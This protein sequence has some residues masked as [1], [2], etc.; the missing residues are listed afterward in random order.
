MIPMPQSLGTKKPY[1][2]LTHEASQAD[3]T[4]DTNAPD[5]IS[6]LFQ[7]DGIL[8]RH[9]PLIFTRPNSFHSPPKKLIENLENLE[10]LLEK[11][12]TNNMGDPAPKPKPKTK[13][14]LTSKTNKPSFSQIIHIFTSPKVINALEKNKFLEEIT[15]D[16]PAP[17][18]TNQTQKIAVVGAGTFKALERA[19]QN[20]PAK[21]NPQNIIVPKTGNTEA[22]INALHDFLAKQKENHSDILFVF[23]ASALA[24]NRLAK[25]FEN[26]VSFVRINAYKTHYAQNI[27]NK[28]NIQT[29]RE[30]A[31]IVFLS[32]SAYDS[33][34]QNFPAEIKSIK[35][36]FCMPGRTSWYLQKMGQKPIVS[37]EASIES[38]RQCIHEVM[39]F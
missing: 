3:L 17:K 38:L 2:L 4:L 1:I 6:S 5:R 28:E 9:I 16:L 29:I 27:N 39:N 23:W 36:T 24:D 26:K 21:I 11:K 14:K 13:I 25:A 7:E 10:N 31:A 32:P 18:N 30:A 12:E 8:V 33:F 19:F 15:K 35:K 20:K 22:L 37:P 34:L